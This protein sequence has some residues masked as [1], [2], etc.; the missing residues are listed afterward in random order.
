MFDKSPYYLYTSGKEILFMEMCIVCDKMFKN[1]GVLARHII[2][3][4]KQT[5]KEYYHQ[6]I[7]K[8]DGIPKCK[9]GCQIEVK[10]NGMKYSEYIKGHYS[11]VHNNWGHNLKA[12]EK[13][14]ETRRRQFLLGERKVWNDGLT[15]ETDKRVK[16]N[17]IQSSEGINSNADELKRRS[18]FMSQQRR[19]GSLPTLYGPNSSQWKGGVSE[20][21][22]IARNDKRL[23]NEWKYPILVRDGFKCTKCKNT[24]NLHIHHDKE[25]M[26]EIVRKHVVDEE[27]KEFEF[28]KL[29]ADKIVDYHIQNKVSGITL[30]GECHGKI[31]PSLNFD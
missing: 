5:F 13:S 11:R 31:H 10:W 30:C 18:A 3:E 25:T 26:S 23:Y 16:N 2:Y 28:K 1:G 9:C 17:G 24:D 27:P 8:T 12:I 15:K 29:I 22:I 14:S 21:N 20:I 6:H 19:N 4:H 7:L